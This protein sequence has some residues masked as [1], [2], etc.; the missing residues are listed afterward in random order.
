MT[1]NFLFFISSGSL[2]KYLIC[3][4]VFCACTFATSMLFLEA[5]IP[6]TCAP[7]L[8]KGSHNKPP[9]QPISKSVKFENEKFLSRFNEK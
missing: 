3:K 7:N 1:S 4:F 9:P 8:A 5:S 2:F 6:V